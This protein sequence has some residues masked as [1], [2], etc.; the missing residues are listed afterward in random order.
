MRVVY[1]LFLGIL[2]L[3]VALAQPFVIVV[4][5]K[6]ND[7]EQGWAQCLAELVAAQKLN[8]ESH[9]PVHGIVTDGKLWEFGKLI[10]G[11][12]IENVESYRYPEKFCPC[13]A[14]ISRGQNLSGQLYTIDHLTRL[15]DV[16]NFIFQSTLS[17]S[18]ATNGLT[19]LKNRTRMTRI[20]RMNADKKFAVSAKI[21]VP[22]FILRG[23]RRRMVNCLNIIA[24]HP[25]TLRQA[26]SDA[27]YF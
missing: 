1:H 17:F 16:L 21:C 15:C 6:R 10:E 24:R 26:Q 12:F 5:A 4:G 8:G 3:E 18:H 13:L 11:T 23:A 9:R 27:C 2:F 14:G 7:F 22:L 19:A 20:G 25:P